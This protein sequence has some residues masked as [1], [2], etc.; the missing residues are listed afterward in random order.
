MGVND[1]LFNYYGAYRGQ[2]QQAQ[3]QQPTIQNSVALKAPKTNS[4]GLAIN[5]SGN[6]PFSSGIQYGYDQAPVA[7]KSN[8]PGQYPS[9][10][11][12]MG[13]SQDKS[14]ADNA[15]TQ[16]QQG[17]SA[18]VAQ[19]YNAMAAGMSNTNQYGVQQSS[20][21]QGTGFD[22]QQQQNL[23]TISQTGQNA[24]QG[25]QNAAAFQKQQNQ[26]NQN[27]GYNIT[28]TGAGYDPGLLP[29]G[30]STNSKG[31][32]AVAAA[33]TAY[34]N[35]TPYVWAG[36]SLTSGVDCS[37]LVQQAYAK[38]GIN[39][40]R[41]TYEQAKSGHVIKG[42]IAN[43]LP[44][45]LIFYNTGSAD[46]NGIGVNSHVAIYLGNGRVLEAQG[47]KTGI[48]EANVGSYNGTIVRP[49]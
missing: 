22:T 6:K 24:L 25:A 28:Y 35:H 4:G 16:Q 46:P 32:Q 43:A 34:Q 31:A 13:L 41:S 11:M 5:N 18:Q 44:G 48:I 7:A 30:A 40:P 12:D 10:L 2:Q 29:A 27:A 15:Y 23:G 45:D 3:Q 26:I 1:F 21:L 37:G 9:S 38:I 14:N 33:M 17:Q 49:W 20:P 36:N 8:L 39:L 42:G 47:T 19:Q